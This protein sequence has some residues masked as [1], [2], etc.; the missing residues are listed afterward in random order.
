[1]TLTL[2][3]TLL[4]IGILLILFEIFLIPGTTVF[5]VIGG[6]VM[7]VAVVFAFLEHGTTIGAIALGVTIVSLSLGLWGF[8]RVMQN[9]KVSL[10]SS[11]EGRVNIFD[12]QCAEG[13]EGV[14]TSA[15]R[16][17]GRARIGGRKIDVYSVG[18]YI[19]RE[20]RV[21]VTRIRDNKVYVK[22]I[23]L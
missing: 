18:P 1:M 19:D 15:L 2:V 12:P 17:G 22:P 20:Q 16:P 7:V 10:S 14:T 23:E 13:D 11:V 21:V 9:D 6:V 5:G 4:L 8:M 3:F